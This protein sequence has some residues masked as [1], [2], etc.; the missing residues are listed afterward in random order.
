MANQDQLD[1][2]G[3]G[4]AAAYCFVGVPFVFILT[5]SK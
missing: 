5:H 2:G 4:D 3:A 1:F